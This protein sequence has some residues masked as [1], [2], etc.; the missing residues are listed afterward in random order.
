METEDSI[1][2]NICLTLFF[3][4]DLCLRTLDQ[5][6]VKLRI[7]ILKTTFV[8]WDC[9]VQQYTYKYCESL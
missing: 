6:A 3:E 8:C 5:I 4:K 9:R 1:F 2:W 7:K